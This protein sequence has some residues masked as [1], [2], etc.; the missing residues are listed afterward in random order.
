MEPAVLLIKPHPQYPVSM[1]ILPPSSPHPMT[2]SLSNP[3]TSTP[4]SKRTITAS[5]HL[6]PL[7]PHRPLLLCQTGVHI[8]SS[9]TSSASL[10]LL[11][12]HQLTQTRRESVYTLNCQSLDAGLRKSCLELASFPI[13]QRFGPLTGSRC[14]PPSWRSTV[15][16][17]V[18]RKRRP[19]SPLGSLLVRCSSR[20]FLGDVVFRR[21]Q[22]RDVSRTGQQGTRERAFP[23]VV[24]KCHD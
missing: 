10:G 3:K 23:R 17:R 1:L 22:P 9:T 4:H 5:A 15:Q 7:T 12:P 16:G 14:P 18:H 24:E 2:Y 11:R 13:C 21:R 20:G 8:P 19:L 6:V